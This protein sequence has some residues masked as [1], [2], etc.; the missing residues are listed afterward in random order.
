MLRAFISMG[1]RNLGPAVL[2]N[3]AQTAMVEAN[4]IRFADAMIS[5]AQRTGLKEV[6]EPAFIFAQQSICPLWSFC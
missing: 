2:I 5:E 1:V 3:T 4:L 6:P